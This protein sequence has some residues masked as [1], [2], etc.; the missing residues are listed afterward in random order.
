MEG[1]YDEEQV[2]GLTLHY[3]VSIRD[4]AIEGRELPLIDFAGHMREAV[5]NMRMTR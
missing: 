2:R 5:G 3:S 1:L 4:G